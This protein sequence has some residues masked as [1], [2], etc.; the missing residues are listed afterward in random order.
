VIEK[1]LV[2]KTLEDLTLE[3]VQKFHKD[4]VQAG[5]KI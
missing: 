1:L 5:I 3:R 4:A 2:P